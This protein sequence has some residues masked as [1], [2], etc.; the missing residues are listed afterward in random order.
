[1]MHVSISSQRRPNKE[2]EFWMNKGTTEYSEYVRKNFVES[3]KLKK[4]ESVVSDDELTLTTTIHWSSEKDYLDFRTDDFIVSEYLNPF[5]AYTDSNGIVVSAMDSKNNMIST[6]GPDPYPNLVIP[7]TWASVEEFAD[8]WLR[9]GMP[10]KFQENSEVFLSD[11]ATAIALFRKGRFQVELYLIHPHPKVP[12]H[13]HPDVEVIK[14][15]LDGKKY[16]YLSNTLRNGESH[17]AGLVLEAEDKGYPLLAI[18]HWLTREPSTIASMWK[19]NTVGPMQD[20]L[21]RRFNPNAFIKDGYAD[22]TRTE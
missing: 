2:V 10:I 6:Q 9:S 12:V 3:G 4:V 5:N 7:E 13:E 14:I 8:W 16:P 21:I 19:G 11:D 15:R 22:I 1:M 20:A 18:Q 17:G